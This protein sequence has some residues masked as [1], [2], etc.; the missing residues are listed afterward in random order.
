MRLLIAVR[1]AAATRP[2]IFAVVFWLRLDCQIEV[3]QFELCHGVLTTP[4]L[5]RWTLPCFSARATRADC[6]AWYKRDGAL[7]MW[8][9]PTLP[10]PQ[11]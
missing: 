11:L 8:C 2:A 1:F 4:E 10:C 7:P 6:W 5:K 3:G 9:S